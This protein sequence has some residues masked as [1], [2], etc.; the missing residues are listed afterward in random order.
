MQPTLQPTSQ[1]LIHKH[2][3]RGIDNTKQ[4]ITCLHY[5]LSRPQTAAI[6]K[7]LGKQ[8]QHTVMNT[9][10]GPHCKNK[11]VRM[12][13]IW[14]VNQLCPAGTPLKGVKC[15]TPFKGAVGTPPFAIAAAYIYTIGCI[16]VFKIL[17]I[18]VTNTAMY[19]YISYKQMMTRM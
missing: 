15:L 19:T 12:T 16:L 7:L 9:E 6:H 1:P 13:P 17:L 11:G 4:Q 14:G 18:L 3:N 8:N 2:N 5:N 10:H